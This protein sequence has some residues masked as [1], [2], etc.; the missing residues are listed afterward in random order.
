MA[1]TAADVASAPKSSTRLCRKP[2][3]AAIAAATINGMTTGS[4]ANCIGASASHHINLIGIGRSGPA[5]DAHGDREQKCYHGRFHDNVSEHQCLNDGIDGGAARCHAICKNWRGQT[6]T[7]S[8]NRKQNVCGCLQDRKRETKVHKMTA[9]DDAIKTNQ[10]EPYGRHV[11]RI[12]KG[13]TH[14]TLRLRS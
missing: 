13:V 12:A 3:P 6:G 10:E 7:K 9:R 2:L 14:F 8:D 11:T 1:S 4:G 5:V